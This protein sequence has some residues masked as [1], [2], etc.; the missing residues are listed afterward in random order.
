MS[1]TLVNVK[2]LRESANTEQTLACVP[3]RSPPGAT[4]S[5]FTGI[6]TRSSCK[7]APL[8]SLR[9]ITGVIEHEASSPDV[10]PPPFVARP[11][12]YS[13][14]SVGEFAAVKIPPAEQATCTSPARP[15]SRTVPCSL[16]VEGHVDSRLLSEP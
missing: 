5:T 9:E 7:V 15:F 16:H 10:D 8:L 13:G 2:L 11:P 12:T 4:D 6:A 3:S 1:R 14:S